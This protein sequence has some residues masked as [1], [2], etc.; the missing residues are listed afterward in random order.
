MKMKN[1]FN[2]VRKHQ[3]VQTYKCREAVTEQK[4]E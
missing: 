4:G 3:S 2:P 1:I